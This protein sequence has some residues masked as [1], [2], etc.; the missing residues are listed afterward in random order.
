M[1]GKQTKGTSS[2]FYR[3]QNQTILTS[4]AQRHLRLW[5]KLMLKRHTVCGFRLARTETLNAAQTHK[6]CKKKSPSFK[7][8]TRG[9][10]FAST[11]WHI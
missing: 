10:T 11:E 2:N 4:L 7:R 5:C 1:I 3:E 6:P 9:V 8:T